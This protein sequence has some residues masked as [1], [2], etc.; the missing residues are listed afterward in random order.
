MLGS[1]FHF[2]KRR[3]D[4]IYHINVTVWKRDWHLWGITPKLNYHW[5]KQRSNFA[6]LY[7]YSDKSV[8]VLLEKTF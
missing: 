4:R 2:D 8:N 3:E 6:S 7:S 1:A 5:K